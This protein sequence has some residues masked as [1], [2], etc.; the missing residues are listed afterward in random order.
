MSNTVFILVRMVHVVSGTLWVGGA[1]LVTVFVAPAIRAA[2]PAGGPVMRQLTQVYRLPHVLAVTGVIAILSGAYV[3]WVSAAGSPSVW[4]QT[5]AGRVY[6]V[7]AI[8]ALLAA[9]IGIGFNIP[10]AN[11]MGVLAASLRG[12]GA[13]P[14]AA[15]ADLLRA[16]N[17]RLATGTRVA[18]ILLM[19]A[20]AAMAVARYI[21]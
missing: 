5:G 13:A 21:A 6:S 15:Q 12:D 18:A 9:V 3:M 1:M 4:L 11:R 19:L 16:L 2:G 7:G 8:S 14:S 20:T 17:V 10:A